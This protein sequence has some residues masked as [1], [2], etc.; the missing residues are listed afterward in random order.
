MVGPQHSGRDGDGWHGSGDQHE[1]DHHA[2]GRP[3]QDGEIGGKQPF[4]ASH[5]PPHHTPCSP[6]PLPPLCLHGI[7]QACVYAAS[8]MLLLPS[9]MLPTYSLSVCA[10]SCP[11][12]VTPGSKR[13]QTRGAGRL[14]LT[15]TQT[16]FHWLVI[17]TAAVAHSPSASFLLLLLVIKSLSHSLYLISCPC[18]FGKQ[19][20]N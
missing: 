3:E 20:N 19:C 13:Y 18:H 10:L 8:C 7:L 14:R 11:L 5:N 2:G 12:A 15:V 4:S 17:T 9:W 6:S 1:R 16:W